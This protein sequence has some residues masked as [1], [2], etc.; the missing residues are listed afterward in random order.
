MLVLKGM[1]TV[2][3]VA[4]LLWLLLLFGEFGLGVWGELRNPDDSSLGE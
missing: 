4:R 3:T 2:V 1:S